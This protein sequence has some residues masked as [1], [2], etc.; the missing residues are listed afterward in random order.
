MARRRAP[1]E[2]RSERA[3]AARS[4]IVADR[5]PSA[6]RRALV[7]LIAVLAITGAGWMALRWFAPGSPASG[8]EP[9]AQPAAPRVEAS[10][11]AATTAAAALARPQS[12]DAVI[13]L[14]Q[15]DWR[16]LDDP[17]RDGWSTEVVQG[18]LSKQ[19]KQIAASI[20]AAVRGEEL[21]TA[22]LELALATVSGTALV[23]PLPPATPQPTAAD[24]ASAGRI[25]LDSNTPQAREAGIAG[26]Q[27]AVAEVVAGLQRAGPSS[28]AHVAWK[29]DGLRVDGDTS[30]A[31]LRL[32]ASAQGAG[33]AVDL[34]S[35]LRSTWHRS[36]DGRWRMAE[37]VAEQSSAALRRGAPWLVDWT[38]A[39]LGDTS[40]R[41]EIALDNDDV[42]QRVARLLPTDPI[43]HTGVAAADVDGD[44]LD[45]L[46][47][48]APTGLP[49]RLLLGLAGGGFRDVTAASGVDYLEETRAVLLLD[50]DGDGRRDLVA[51]TSAGLMLAANTTKSGETPRF[52][53]ARRLL[54][55]T[56]AHS[57]SAA[58]VDGDGDLDLYAGVFYGGGERGNAG[59]PIP[60][61]YH[62]ADNGGR[63]ALLRNEGGLRFEDATVALGLDVHNRR[64]TQ[65]S[66]FLDVDQDGDQDLYVANDHGRNAYYRNDGG[67]FEEI[68]ESA[69]L[70]DMAAGMSVHFGDADGDGDFD[71]Y[72][73]NMYSS[74]G[75]RIVPQHGF[76]TGGAAAARADVLRHARGNSLFVAG[77]N[78]SFDDASERAGAMVAG[79]AWG[80]RFVD[81][82]ADGRQDLL[83]ANGL[84]TRSD[85]GDL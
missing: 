78:G 6:G 34:Q 35:R 17:S 3:G 20:E 28:L 38:D 24:G 71:L 56:V 52:G 2:R 67:H 54:G 46:Y 10:A 75:G 8:M 4:A 64:F 60:I 73:S 62:D 26:L 7:A 39:W 79:W 27:A 57:L 11:T 13:T 66:G 19:L 84:F 61:P 43:G 80:S 85:P 36:D 68:A 59:F 16:G 74:A 55:S 32:F 44:G 81:L 53:P 40:L 33:G 14:D 58:D 18:A 15:S 69:G 37:L 76:G 42:L 50:L 77:A 23:G 29:I 48:A 47:I 22:W 82:D 65:A 83:V 72:V 5:S 30:Q 12:D 49:N 1:N 21:T 41:A 51:A 45:D 25:T 63:N 31:T 9:S 70:E